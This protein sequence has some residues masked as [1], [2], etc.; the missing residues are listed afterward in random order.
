ML[1]T[2]DTEQDLVLGPSQYW[3]LCLRPK[4][5]EVL[6]KKLPPN[7]RVEVVDTNVVVSVK[8]RSERDLTKRF[9]EVESSVPPNN[10]VEL[11]VQVLPHSQR[12]YRR[13]SSQ[14]AACVATS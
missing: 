1:V 13:H 7:R 6:S 14:L 3:S 5:E 4:L 9:D 10:G 8:E 11:A 12:E 2:K